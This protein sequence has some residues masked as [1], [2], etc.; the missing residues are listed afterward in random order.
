MI[1]KIAGV[2]DIYCGLNMVNMYIGAVCTYLQ[3]DDYMEMKSPPL[4]DVPC[5][6]PVYQK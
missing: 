1:L 4:L 2:T 6:C 3:R 5:F